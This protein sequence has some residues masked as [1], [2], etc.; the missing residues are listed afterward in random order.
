[1]YS[2]AYEESN[3]ALS[4][5]MYI[6]MVCSE[7]YTDLTPETAAQILGRAGELSS[8]DG[9]TAS[10]MYALIKIAADQGEFD[11]AIKT[12]VDLYGLTGDEGIADL[13]RSLIGEAQGASGD[14]E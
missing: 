5:I 12:A 4:E 8:A 1:M 6:K 10:A 14:G 7:D 13:A 11:T 3:Y 2:L 9:T